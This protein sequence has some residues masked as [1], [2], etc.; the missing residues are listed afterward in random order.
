MA[1]KNISSAWKTHLKTGFPPTDRFFVDF[2]QQEYPP[3]STGADP[4]AHNLG[5]KKIYPDDNRP[6]SFDGAIFKA[7]TN[8]VQDPEDLTTANW[9]NVNSTDELSD[10]YF[11]GKRFTKMNTT[12]AWGYI[13]QTITFTGDG[14][15]GFQVTFRKGIVCTGVSYITIRDTTVGSAVGSLNIN[16]TTEVVAGTDGATLHNYE[17]IDSETVIIWG[18]T[19]AI[20]AANN[21]QIRMRH[22]TDAESV[23]ITAV[24]AEDSS[25]PTPY[26][27]GSRSAA[28]PVYVC[29]MPDSG[30]FTIRLVVEPWFVYLTTNYMIICGWDVDAT[31][32]FIIYYNRDN[33]TMSIYWVDGGTGR[34]LVSQQFDDDINQLLI[35]DVAIDLTGGQTG[36]QLWI[37]RVS[38]DTDW[39]GAPDAKSSGF[40]LFSMGHGG[41]AYPADSLFNQTILIPDH[42]A[43]DADVQNDYKSVKKEMIVWN[44]NGEGVGRTRTNITRHVLKKRY[45]KTPTFKANRLSLDLKSVNG[46]FADDQYDAFDP[47]NDVFNGESTQKYMQHSCPVIAETWYGHDHEPYF[48]GRVDTKLFARRSGAGLASM[49]SITAEDAIAEIALKQK[50]K[51]RSWEDKKLSDSTEAD[52]LL[53]LIARL[54]TQKEIYNFLANSSFENATISDSWTVAGAGATFSKV[55]GGL[56]GSNQGDLVYGAAACTVIQTVTFTG[57]KKLNVGETWTFYLWLKSASACGDNITLEERDSVGLNDSSDT[58]FA[59]D[60]GEG[61]KLFSVSHTIAY[62]DSDRLRVEINLNDAGVTLSLDGAMLVQ[63]DRAYNWFVLNNNDGD[64]G[65]EA[66]EAADDA[67]YAAYDTVGFDVDFVNIVHPWAVIDQD[68][69]VWKPLK[70]LAIASIQTYIG[71]DPC[72]TLKFRAMLATGYADPSSLETIGDNDFRNI[73]TRLSKINKIEIF[74]N[75]ITKDTDIS[76]AWD[77]HS[78]GLFGDGQLVYINLANGDTWPDPAIYGE[79]WAKYINFKKPTDL[80]GPAGYI[81][82]V[83]AMVGG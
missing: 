64:G 17:W 57:T 31:H 72:G 6:G 74:G 12:A 51:A 65:V 20:T 16:W 28:R 2:R 33:D 10:Y 53:H 34:F 7:T 25:Y 42:V 81:S 61:W 76:Q 83:E 32:R 1:I 46:E 35:I 40:A 14:A 27:N 30:K 59:F 3:L 56:F 23:F 69:S 29:P 78:V 79:Y 52:S 80:P 60:G 49:I 8:L 66:T 41:G 48:I 9:T 67:D 37:N 38:R 68:E 24:E 82:F 21:H 73:N 13:Y 54:A 77:A 50:R 22:S 43:T 18:F 26:V 55:A 15:K 11:E 36:S 71:L 47:D 75:H 58:A 19:G 4:T 70:E 45:S 39:E 63:N 5:Y 62:S 44:F